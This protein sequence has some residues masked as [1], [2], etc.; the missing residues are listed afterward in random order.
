MKKCMISQP[1]RNLT[2]D[3]IC[4][5]RFKAM[6]EIHNLGYEFVSSYFSDEYN[7][8]KNITNIPVYY[9]GISLM[10]MAE[11][12]AVYFCKGWEDARGCVIEHEVAQKYDIECIYE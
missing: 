6:N 1:M 10:K 3:E 4:D 7:P 9:L 8:G 11:C 12:D 2:D 5:I